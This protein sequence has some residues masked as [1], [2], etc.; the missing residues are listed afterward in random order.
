LQHHRHEAT[1]APTSAFT[2]D[3]EDWYQSCVDPDAGV[4]ERVVRNMDR[5]LE[6]LDEARVKGTFFVQG[7]VAETFPA[8][9]ERI[10]VE[11][12]EVQSHSYTHRPLSRMSRSQVQA[13]L[14]RGRA[15]VEDAAGV[16]VTA[17]RAP[18]FSIG[19]ENTWAL[20]SLADEGFRVDSSIFPIQMRR[21][22]IGEWTVAPQSVSL[23]NGK[24][25]LEVP[26]AVL[27]VAGRRVPV[28]GGG[29]LR[30]WPGRFVRR[31][32]EAILAEGRPPIFYCHPYEFNEREL[33]DYRREI[34]YRTRLA[35][36]TGRGSFVRRL[37]QLL[38]QLEFGR[39]D[40]VLRGWQLA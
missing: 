4:T 7:Q 9:I 25:I 39:L 1:R 38:V 29:Y 16:A 19:T 11:G 5:V 27:A 36:A 28:G 15:A 31:A 17:F 13:E 20:E 12:H 24:T 33:D 26:V 32:F 3:V 40:D 6:I 35:Q 22:G 14:Q 18:D 30:L 37:R 2:V 21:Y 23:P 34:P 10:A 8:L